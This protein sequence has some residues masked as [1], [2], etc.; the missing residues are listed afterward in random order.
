MSEIELQV[1]DF[2]KIILFEVTVEVRNL[3]V[4][5]L[6]NQPPT[7]KMVCAAVYIIFSAKRDVAEGLTG[8]ISGV[9]HGETDL[10]RLK[11]GV[12]VPFMEEGTQIGFIDLETRTLFHA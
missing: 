3:A 10:K 5:M 8:F 7:V 1:N 6:F 11:V 4:K 9:S 12:S 2:G